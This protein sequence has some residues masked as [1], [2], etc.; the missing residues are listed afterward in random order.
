M[1]T[2]YLALFSMILFALVACENNTPQENKHETYVDN[3]ISQSQN[4]YTEG[5]TQNLL[6]VWERD[7]MF[8][9]DDDWQT[10]EETMI[11]NGEHYYMGLALRKYSF[12]ANGKCQES[13]RSV[14][15]EFEGIEE[16]IVEF[17]WL[18]DAETHTLVL[19]SDKGNKIERKVSGINSEYLILDYYDSVNSHNTREIYKRKVE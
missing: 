7:S 11:L 12:N 16:R 1:K 4:L 10:I 8:T 13:T 18:Y 17:D 6:G 14:L 3:L 19:I 5:I 9:Y 15:L 2:K